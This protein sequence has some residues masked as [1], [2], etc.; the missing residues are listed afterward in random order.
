MGGVST[1]AAEAYERRCCCTSGCDER[2]TGNTET[3]V[4]LARVQ[5]ADEEMDESYSNVVKVTTDQSVEAAPVV[6]HRSTPSS[7]EDVQTPSSAS[8]DRARS[9]RK[10][11]SGGHLPPI[12]TSF[13]T[14]SIQ[15]NDIDLLYDFHLLGEGSSDIIEALSAP[16]SPSSAKSH[17]GHKSSAGKKR[18]VSIVVEV[19]TEST[20]MKATTRPH[21]RK[22]DFVKAARLDIQEWTQKCNIPAFSSVTDA[23]SS[24]VA[25]VI[26]IG[27]QVDLQKFAKHV[28][29]LANQSRDYFWQPVERQAVLTVLIV[30]GNEN[31]HLPSNLQAVLAKY[32]ELQVVFFPRDADPKAIFQQLAQQMPGKV[33]LREQFVRKLAQANL[34]NASGVTKTISRDSRASGR[35]SGK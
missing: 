7:R 31:Q 20:A 15:D 8:K 23:C 28:E 33:G 22:P 5:V 34:A 21:P 1:K 6:S 30:L 13:G 29:D 9:P 26:R 18:T 12:N 17:K 27:G 4:P 10:K 35:S 25:F 24:A 2:V 3:I 19:P 16:T 14:T 32:T 11:R